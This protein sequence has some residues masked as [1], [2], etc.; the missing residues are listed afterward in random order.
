MQVPL[1]NNHPVVQLEQAL[2]LLQIKQ[3]TPHELQIVPFGANPGRQLIHVSFYNAYPSL[4]T[5]HI[6]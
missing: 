2:K 4:Q 1:A 3:L 5:L 6:D